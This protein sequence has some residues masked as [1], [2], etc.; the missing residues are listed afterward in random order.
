MINT[1]TSISFPNR[2]I[3]REAGNRFFVF[4]KIFITNDDAMSTKTEMA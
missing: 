2:N 3:S 1:E 4:E